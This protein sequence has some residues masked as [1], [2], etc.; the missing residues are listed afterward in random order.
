M[1][2][3]TLT[4]VCLFIYLFIYLFV[5]RSVSLTRLLSDS[6]YLSNLSDCSGVTKR[7]LLCV[8]CDKL[9]IHH[10]AL[11]Y[12]R[13]LLRISSELHQYNTCCM[14]CVFRHVY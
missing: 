1:E 13:E 6:S 8:M 7:C 10:N 14:H 11:S 12:P 4:T 5:M 9:Y 2:H 3:I